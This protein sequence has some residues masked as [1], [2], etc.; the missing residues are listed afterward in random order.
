MFN[1]SK[2]NLTVH[3]IQCIILLITIIIA[4]TSSEILRKF[5]ALVSAFLLGIS[6][7]KT[8]YII[9]NRK[10]NKNG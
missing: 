6:C 5:L 10:E 7:Q 8:I 4:F 1:S 9:K 2:E 3:I